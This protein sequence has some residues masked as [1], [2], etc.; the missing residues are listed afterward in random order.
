MQLLMHM[1]HASYVVT[2][3][4]LSDARR[5]KYVMVSTLE[6]GYE[7]AMAYADRS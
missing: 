6:Q 3:I 7:C 5:D 1:C 4:A 2:G